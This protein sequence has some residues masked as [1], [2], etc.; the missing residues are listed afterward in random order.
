MSNGRACDD[1]DIYQ[2]AF[3]EDAH[4]LLAWGYADSR[5]RIGPDN[6]EEVITA[7]IAEAI[8]R[9]I[10]DPRTPESFTR[11]SIH[12]VHFVSPGGQTGKRQLKLDLMIEQCGIRPKRHFV[13]EAKRLKTGSHPI[14]EYTGKDGL[15]R[16]VS[17]RY[18][19]ED[20]EAAMVGYM[21]NRDASHWFSELGRVFSNDEASGKKAL[22]VTE[23]LRE[24]TVIH[25]LKDEWASAHLRSNRTQILVF[26]VLL[27][28]S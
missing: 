8:D 1:W 20:P 6:E 21:Q 10:D 28:C 7:Y 27:D 3:R 16:F 9:R 11:Y 25:E 14:G 22:R 12:N 13:F 23:Q 4:Q 17:G 15:G 19:A 2:R 18:A 24:I 26:H 5:N